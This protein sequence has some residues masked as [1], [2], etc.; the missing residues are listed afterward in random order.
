[1]TANKIHDAFHRSGPLASLRLKNTWGGALTSED[2]LKIRFSVYSFSTCKMGLY[3]WGLILGGPIYG[4]TFVLVFWWAYI[5]GAY[6][7]GCLYTEIYG[8]LH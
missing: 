5:R 4:T 3:F 1:M 6:I 8:N 2:L 7:Q